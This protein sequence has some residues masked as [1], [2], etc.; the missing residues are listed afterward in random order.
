MKLKQLYKHD[1]TLTQIGNDM[2]PAVQQ[3][4]RKIFDLMPGANP[5]HVRQM[6]TS[7]LMMESSKR[8]VNVKKAKAK[9]KISPSRRQSRT[10]VW[11]NNQS[12][13]PTDD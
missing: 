6:V 10:S 3:G 13:K 1:L 12:W 11:S 7:A 9:E 2:W 5:M 8:I 4:M